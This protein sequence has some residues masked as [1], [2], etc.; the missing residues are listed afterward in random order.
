MIKSF[1]LSRL[2]LFTVAHDHRRLVFV[3]TTCRE[4]NLV[5]V[6]LPIKVSRA[7][8]Q[9]NRRGHRGDCCKQDSACLIMLQI[10]VPG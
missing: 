2:M 1:L 10:V 3:E 5:V 6:V 9:H 8:I 4:V 7:E